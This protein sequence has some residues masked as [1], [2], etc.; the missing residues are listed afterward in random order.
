MSRN[1]NRANYFGFSPRLAL[2]ATV[3]FNCNRVFNG[4]E[5]I[6]LNPRR[7]RG[8]FRYC[9]SYPAPIIFKK[10]YYINLYFNI[11]NNNNNNN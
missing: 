11:N 6:F 3:L 8:R 4:F 5:F 9:N 10:N 1:D 7:V 2:N